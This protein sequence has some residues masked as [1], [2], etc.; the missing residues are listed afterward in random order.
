VFV[1]RNGDPW[2]FRRTRDEK[3]VWTILEQA[4]GSQDGVI[5]DEAEEI[6]HLLGSKG[7]LEYRDLLKR[8]SAEKK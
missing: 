5:R 6:I 7:Y 1:D 8:N 3:G 2:F 4:M